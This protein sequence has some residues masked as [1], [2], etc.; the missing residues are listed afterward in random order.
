MG[1]CALWPIT[2]CSPTTMPPAVIAPSCVASAPTSC[3]NLCGIH[4]RGDATFQHM[5]AN[6][7]VSGDLRWSV[8]LLSMGK[9]LSL[10]SCPT[11]V[12]PVLS[13]SSCTVQTHAKMS[14]HWGNMCFRRQTKTEDVKFLVCLGAL[15]ITPTKI[16]NY[17]HGRLR[18]S[19]N[20]HKHGASLALETCR[21]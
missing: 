1:G 12:L 14:C 20:H 11:S 6:G 3:R 5:Q 9:R 7:A 16:G 10:W 13:N 19:Q 21:I 17:Q 15:G 18:L 2:H 8:R 4:M